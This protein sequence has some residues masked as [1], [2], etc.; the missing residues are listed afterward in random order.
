MPAKKHKSRKIANLL[1][2]L[3]QNSDMRRALALKNTWLTHLSGVFSV[4]VPLVESALRYWARWGSL[5]DWGVTGPRRVLLP[6]FLPHQAAPEWR[7]KE[8]VGGALSPLSLRS[9]YFCKSW[10]EWNER[11][12]SYIECIVHT[13]EKIAVQKKLHSTLCSRIKS[14]SAPAKSKN[15]MC[16]ACNERG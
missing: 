12:P 10:A 13:A 6:R 15:K 8:V 3:E 5:A 11:A 2:M 14:C 4:G 16:L 1:R 7:P 9:P